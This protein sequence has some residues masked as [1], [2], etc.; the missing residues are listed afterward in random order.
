PRGASPC[1]R[2]AARRAL[3]HGRPSRRARLQPRPAS[4]PS[5]TRAVSTDGAMLVATLSSC[6][7]APDTLTVAIALLPGELPAYR[8]VI[9]DFERASGWRTIVVPQGY[10]DIRRALAAE[11]AAGRGTLDLVE[12]D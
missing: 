1:G 12:L 11:S 7:P 4:R 2:A 9:A 10:A 6:A 8:A 3:P 5:V